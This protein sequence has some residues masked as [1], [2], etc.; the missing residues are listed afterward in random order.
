VR[1]LKGVSAVPSSRLTARDV[2]NARRVIATRSALEK[3]QEALA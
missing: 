1:N 3:L 2:M